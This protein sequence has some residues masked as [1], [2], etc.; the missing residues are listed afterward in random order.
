MKEATVPCLWILHILSFP[1]D[2]GIFTAPRGILLRRG[3]WP[4]SSPG[5]TPVPTTSS[6]P[7]FSTF[8]G[9]SQ[10]HKSSDTNKNSSE[11]FSQG[12]GPLV[13]GFAPRKDID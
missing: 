3:T 10:E 9:L 12:S 6:L 8:L 2:T 5:V 11:P 1:D 4:L 7:D 13:Q